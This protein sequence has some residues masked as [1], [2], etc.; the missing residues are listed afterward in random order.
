[1]YKHQNN[2]IVEFQKLSLDRLSFQKIATN[3]SSRNIA[4]FCNLIVDFT[5]T[6][7][8]KQIVLSYNTLL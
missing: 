5:R 6:L 8:A 7:S 2:F 4:K 1:M 3:S